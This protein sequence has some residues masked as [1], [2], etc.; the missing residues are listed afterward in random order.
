MINGE[1]ML[2]TF[3]TRDRRQQTNEGNDPWKWWEDLSGHPINRTLHSILHSMQRRDIDQAVRQL[4]L[5]GIAP[6]VR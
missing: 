5:Y 3:A 1:A 4:P 2:H 6:G